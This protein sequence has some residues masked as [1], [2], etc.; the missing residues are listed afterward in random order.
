MCAFTA[1]R[2]A[3]LS[4][5]MQLST[6]DRNYNQIQEG[7]FRI[8][9]QCRGMP[10]PIQRPLTS[11]VIGFAQVNIANGG[12]ST[13]NSA[14]P[15]S[16][17]S[18]TV[19]SRLAANMAAVSRTTKLAD[20]LTKQA[21][22]GTLFVGFNELNGWEELYS[23]TELMKNKPKMVL[24][25][26]ASGF[27]Y[28]HV[29]ASSAH[30]YSLGLVAAVPFSVVKEYKAATTAS[31]SSSQFSRGVLHTYFPSLD[32]HVLVLHLSPKSA[33][34]RLAEVSQIL[35]IA[36]PLLESSGRVVLMGDFNT[37][38]PYDKR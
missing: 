9:A 7:T 21:N 19:A 28:S 26:A 20:W 25:A 14:A 38:S 33:A 32:L 5:P 36:R 1:R 8:T 18:S 29:M 16:S 15:S 2:A 13:S 22:M 35:E 34:V 10:E 23:R 31:S 30:P 4:Q 24:T 11:R 27:T 3:L 12:G 37:L 17:S 6:N